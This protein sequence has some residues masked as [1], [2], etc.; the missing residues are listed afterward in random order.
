MA[1]LKKSWTLN[2]EAFRLFLAWLDDGVDSQS[3]SDPEL[4]RRLVLHLV[5]VRRSHLNSRC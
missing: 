2:P 1:E 3:E 4:R 5:S